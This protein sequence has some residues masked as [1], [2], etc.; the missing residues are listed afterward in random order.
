MFVCK[1][2]YHTIKKGLQRRGWVELDCP[3]AAL[4]VEKKDRKEK[5]DNLTAY[6]S[7]DSDDDNCNDDSASDSDQSS[8]EDSSEGYRML[9]SFLVDGK[10]HA[11]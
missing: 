10:C 8:D 11:Y 6:N 1:G 2:G 7:D 4:T 9:V 3:S 5:E